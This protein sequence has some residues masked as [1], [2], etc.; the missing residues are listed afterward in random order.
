MLTTIRVTKHHKAGVVLPFWIVIIPPYRT[1]E[2]SKFV[3]VLSSRGR[4]SRSHMSF[5]CKRLERT[6]AELVHWNNKVRR[7]GKHSFFHV[8]AVWKSRRWLFIAWYL[9]E[10]EIER[11]S[12]KG[13]CIWALKFKTKSEKRVKYSKNS[14]KGSQ[15]GTARHSICLCRM[16]KNPGSGRVCLCTLVSG[17]CRFEDQILDTV[18]WWNVRVKTCQDQNNFR[19]VKPVWDFEWQA[20]A[21][22]TCDTVADESWRGLLGL[23]KVIYTTNQG[24]LTL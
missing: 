20:A 3:P 11:V 18:R 5:D 14:R 7:I 2:R 22:S 4:F 8:L 24:I 17:R 13:T 19:K 21:S 15:K 6:Y 16:I 9:N 23:Y 10:R 1:I 12:D